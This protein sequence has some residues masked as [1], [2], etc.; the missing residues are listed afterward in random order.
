LNVVQVEDGKTVGYIFVRYA[1]IDNDTLRFSTLNED[2][3]KAAISS[4]QI[5]GTTRGDGLTSE[6]AI[7]AESGEIENYLRRDGG[8]LFTK[9]LVL[10]RVQDR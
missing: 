6:T 2:V 8:K 3:L 5:K 1:L 9:S 7:T 4:G 10:R